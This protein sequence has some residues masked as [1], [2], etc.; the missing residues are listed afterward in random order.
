MILRSK[1]RNL[2]DNQ[3]KET[4]IKNLQQ[5]INFTQRSNSWFIEKTNISK[6]D[7]ENL[8]NGEGDILNNIEKILQLYGIENKL[9]FHQEDFKLPERPRNRLITDLPSIHRE[10]VKNEE[11]EFKL[12]ME[13]LD[14]FV[15]IFELLKANQVNKVHYK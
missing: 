15:N 2:M 4:I 7:F 12:T 9:Y 8:L 14:D 10:E 3:S 13:M 1:G 11:T 5:F 6:E